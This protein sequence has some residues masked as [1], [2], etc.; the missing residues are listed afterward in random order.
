M[1]DILRDPMEGLPGPCGSTC[2]GVILAGAAALTLAG[3]TWTKIRR[4]K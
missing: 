3:L 2:L 4:S 1:N